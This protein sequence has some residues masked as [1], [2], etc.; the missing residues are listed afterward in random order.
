MICGASQPATRERSA[1][2]SVLIIV[3]WVALGLVA[4]TLYFA[5][6]MRL[7]LQASDNQIASLQASAA[8]DGV[9]RYVTNLFT[10]YGEPGTPLDTTLFEVEDLRVGE[11]TVWMLGRDTNLWQQTLTEPSFGLIDESA[12][13]NLNTATAAMFEALPFMTPE[14]AAS[15]VDWRDA[16]SDVS[17]NGAEDEYYARL[18]PPYR[19]KNADFESV[20]ELRLVAGATLALLMGEDTNLNGILDPNEDDGDDSYPA[21]NQNGRLDPGLLEYVTIATYEP[22][23]GSGGTNRVDVSNPN[24]PG[25]TN[26]LQAQFGP[27]RTTQLLNQLGNQA[28]FRSVLEFGLKAG[29]TSDEIAQI[30]GELTVTNASTLKGLVNVN[31]ASAEVLA[32]VPGI[33]ADHA[34]TLVSARAS[35]ANSGTSIAWIIDTL[36]NDGAIEAAP[37]LTSRGY[38]FTLDAAAVGRHQRG[39]HRARFLIDTAGETPRIASRRDLTHLGWALG[40]ELRRE[41]RSTPP[42]VR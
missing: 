15:I 18:N 24:D 40:Q 10:T 22:N 38:Q 11:A 6:S 39:Y 26:V 27:N 1:R 4:V 12:K 42:T 23:T 20:D 36:G 16:D 29:M 32:C 37:F 33:G 28:S 17:D 7:Q 25:V 35:A 9:A 31:T 8:V 3:L 30:E 13:L 34:S 41:L 2:G 21:D 5:Q 19:C 14:F